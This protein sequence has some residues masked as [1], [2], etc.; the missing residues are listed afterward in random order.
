MRITD[1]DEKYNIFLYDDLTSPDCE[2]DDYYCLKAN[3]LL[4]ARTGASTGKTYLYS[5]D[6]GK[7]YFAGFL[8]RFRL[9][10]VNS[11]YIYYQTKT[12]KYNNWVS[13]YSKRSGQPGINANE[14][15]KLKIE[16][17]SIEEQ[18]KIACFLSTLDT[19]IYNLE[20]KSN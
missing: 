3:D 13:I 10:N 19:K 1:I 12:A 8:I 18:N 2:L 15:S 20:N 9:Q 11:K 16:V 7:V 14:Y 17:C 4:F 5:I 6:D